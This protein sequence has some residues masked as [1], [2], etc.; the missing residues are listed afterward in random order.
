MLSSYFIS[1]LWS[2]VVKNFD[3]F[4]AIDCNVSLFP[5]VFV[6]TQKGPSGYLSV[7]VIQYKWI[8]F[9]QSGK[10]A[11]SKEK[12]ALSWSKQATKSLKIE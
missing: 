3:S 2:L 10:I 8:S 11:L 7:L 4:K 6:A 12:Q 9:W 1:R 5:I